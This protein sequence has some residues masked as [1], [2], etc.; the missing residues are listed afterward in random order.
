MV[1]VKFWAL[2]SMELDGASPDQ[3]RQRLNR[4]DQEQMIEYADQTD[5]ANNNGRLPEYVS[6]VTNR[7]IPANNVGKKPK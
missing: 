5:R 2:K 3:A 6:A 1:R 4:F 7:S